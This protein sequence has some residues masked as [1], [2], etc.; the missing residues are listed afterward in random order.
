MTYREAT[1][2]FYTGTGNSY[3]VATWLAEAA[4]DAG[5]A[6]T[7]RPIGAARPVE[8]IGQGES[9][10]LGLVMP[11]HGFTAPWAMLRFA[12]RLPRRRST[13]A[14]VIATRARGKIGPLFTPGIEGTAT[15]LIALILALKGYRVR[16]VTG[17][18]MPSNWIAVHPGFSAGTVASIKAR[19]REKVARFS[20]AILSGGRRFTGWL[21]LLIG[22]Y[23]FH[24]SL[25]YLLLGRLFLA[26]MFFASERCT[27]CGLCAAHCPNHAIEM[28]GCGKH[29]RPYW[30]FRCESCMRCMGYCP[31]RAVEANYLLGIGVYLLAA[32]IPTTALLAWLTARAPAL[33]F[34]S[35]TPRW[36]LESVYALVALG[37]LYPLLHFLLGVGWINRF[38]TFITPTHYYRRYHEPEAT[39]KE[40][41]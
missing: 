10:L 2:Y 20:D 22:L 11:T 9:A 40:L 36:V 6:V 27:G 8:E 25:A 21:P 15:C 13:R 14:V 37:L 29:L 39:L 3:R 12:L 31:T 30:T 23:F 26:K 5:A 1:L 17:V 32:L 7:L 41:E 16:G 28:R 4:R 38:F 34:L 19:A 33:A 24:I 18:D 35:G